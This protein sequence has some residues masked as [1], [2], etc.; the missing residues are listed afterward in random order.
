MILDLSFAC[1]DTA[2]NKTLSVNSTTIKTA[3]AASI[4]QLRQALL[5]IIYAFATAPADQPIFIAKW[6]TKDGFWR[7][8]CAPGKEWNFAYLLSSPTTALTLVVPSALQ[9]VW[10]ES[11]AYF[12]TA[13]ETSRDVAATYANT[14]LGS[15]PRHQFLADMPPSNHSTSRGPV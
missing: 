15:I 1:R 5:R 11:P 13:S 7:L 10:I 3:P 8:D 4:D 9:M 12:C 14:P 2:G 6:D